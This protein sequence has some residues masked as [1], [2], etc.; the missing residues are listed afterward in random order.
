MEEYM[1]KEVTEGI[2]GTGIRAGII[3]NSP[4]RNTP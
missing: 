1:L 2:E 4:R 3:K